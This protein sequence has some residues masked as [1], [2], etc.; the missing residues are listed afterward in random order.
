M[1]KIC[2]SLAG[3]DAAALYAQA[4]Q[5]HQA[6]DVLEIRLD[7]MKRP[8]PGKCCSLLRQPLLFTNRPTWEGGAFRGSEEE[9]LAPLLEAIR[10]GAAYI[11]FELR[12]DTEHRQHI[13]AAMQAGASQLI[14]SWHD[15]EGTPS[16]QHLEEIFGQMLASGAHAGKIVT[17]AQGPEDVL[18]VLALHQHAAQAAFPLSS[19]CMGEAGRISRLATMYLGGFMTYTCLHAVQATAPGQLSLSQLRDLIQILSPRTLE[20]SHAAY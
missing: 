11:D 8:E 20:Q 17:T 5:A 12:A 6:A 1:T 15:F 2:V 4:Q 19:F 14:L 3:A 16:A 18:R 7:S 9:R 10:L 13:L